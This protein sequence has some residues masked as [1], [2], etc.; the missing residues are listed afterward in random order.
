M[1]GEGDQ[2][3][4]ETTPT[5]NTM[6][7][8]VPGPKIARINLTLELGG[9]TRESWG[10]HRGGPSQLARHHGGAVGGAGANQAQQRP[11]R[12]GLCDCAG[13]GQ[14]LLNS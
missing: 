5:R 2:V 7:C 12:D 8:T 9:G 4:A 14:L 1:T 3:L 13:V 10:A 6:N 11:K